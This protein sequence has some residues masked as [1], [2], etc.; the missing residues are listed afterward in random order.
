[1]YCDALYIPKKDH[2]FGYPKV[3]FCL[4]ES[5]V[6]PWSRTMTCTLLDRFYWIKKD[7]FRIVYKKRLRLSGVDSEKELV[8]PRY[9]VLKKFGNLL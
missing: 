5:F 8:A 9:K 4:T 2:G 6:H 3:E 1:M 7:Q